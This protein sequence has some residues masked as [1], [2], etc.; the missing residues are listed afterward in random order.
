LINASDRRQR[1]FE[2]LLAG[3]RQSVISDSSSLQVGQDNP[4]RG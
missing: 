2:E 4:Q 3:V 1:E